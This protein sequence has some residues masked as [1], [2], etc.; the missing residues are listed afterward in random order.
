V[1]VEEF[2][3]SSLPQPQCRILE[4]GAGKGELARALAVQDHRVTAIDPQ[5]PNDS[6][7][8][9]V[10][11]EAFTD[12]GPFDAVVAITSLHHI[13]NLEACLEKIHGLLRLDG[14]LILLEF[15]WERMDERTADWCVSQGALAGD[16]P[17]TMSS[18]DFLNRWNR[19][20]QGLHD[21]ATMRQALDRFFF[22]KV[23]EWVPFIAEHLE[24]PDLVEAERSLLHSGAINPIGF[25]YV[26]VRKP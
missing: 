15:G 14:P 9:K 26:G 17:G 16:Q 6:I 23:F 10:S 19:E 18:S 13:H 4:V 1:N 8:Q 5:G 3:A 7:V 24:R 22:L 20:H 11:L 2:V 25:H 21:S 12:P